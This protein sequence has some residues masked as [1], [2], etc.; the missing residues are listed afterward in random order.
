MNRVRTHSRTR[1]G[2]TLASVVGA[3]LVPLAPVASAGTATGANTFT[4]RPAGT[5]RLS[6]FTLS[7]STGRD[8][9]TD[10]ASSYNLAT[11][12]FRFL[13]NQ[14]FSPDTVLFSRDEINFASGRYYCCAYQ[15]NG[16]R[17]HFDVTT[18][19]ANGNYNGDIYHR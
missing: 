6:D 2:L 7:R 17:A 19:A 9:D 10:V 18:P 8:V 5:A 14:S 13:Y 4:T 1:I 16:N 15:G 12:S 11:Y 3:V